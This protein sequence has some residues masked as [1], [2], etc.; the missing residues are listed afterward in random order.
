LAVF[1]VTRHPKSNDAQDLADVPELMRHL[2][3]DWRA[4]TTWRCVAADFKAAASGK[5]IEGAAV[6]LWL[7]LILESGRMPSEV[8]PAS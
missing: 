7:V 4:R 2:P 6:A 5:D 8:R 1:S 3:E